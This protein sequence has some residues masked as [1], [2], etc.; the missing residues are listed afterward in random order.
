MWR[1]GNVTKYGQYLPFV[2]FND[3]GVIFKKII[4]YNAYNH[5]LDDYGYYYYQ[6]HK[7]ETGDVIVVITMCYMP[8]SVIT[9]ETQNMIIG[10]F[11]GY[12]W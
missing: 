1:S 6:R 9:D 7:N 5:K 3:C 8:Y 12:L 11:N 4:I 2:L 10:Y